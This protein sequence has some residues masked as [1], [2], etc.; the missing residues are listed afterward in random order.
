MNQTSTQHQHKSRFQNV[1]QPNLNSNRIQFNR[2]LHSLL[3]IR[4][5]NNRA[6]PTTKASEGD[7]RFQ[8]VSGNTKRQHKLVDGTNFQRPHGVVLKQGL[9]SFSAVQLYS[10]R[11]RGARSFKAFRSGFNFFVY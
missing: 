10:F 11:S 2:E 7:S 1:N 6:S 8:D 9:I 4:R 3:S 5:Q